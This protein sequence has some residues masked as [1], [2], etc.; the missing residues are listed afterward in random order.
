MEILTHPERLD[1]MLPWGKLIQEYF[2][3]LPIFDKELKK[4]P[5]QNRPVRMFLHNLTVQ[6]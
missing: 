5:D 6:G 4:H 1:Q 3:K 2:G